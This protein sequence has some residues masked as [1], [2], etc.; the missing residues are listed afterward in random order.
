MTVKLSELFSCEPDIV[1]YSKEDLLL[2]DIRMDFIF[3]LADHLGM[4]YGEFDASPTNLCYLQ[5]R[6]LRPGYRTTFSKADLRKY[7][8]A[9][10]RSG[11]HHVDRDH[12][13]FLRSMLL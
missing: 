8:L 13:T 4:S 6:D 11:I 2:L 1:E 9:T 5:D 10:L 3:L 7:L 12:I